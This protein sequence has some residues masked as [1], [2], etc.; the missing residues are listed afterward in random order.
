M[1]CTDPDRGWIE[2]FYELGIT[3]G[4]SATP[5]DFCAE[6][7]ATRAQMAVFLATAMVL[8]GTVPA[9][10]TVP[11]VGSYNCTTGGTSLFADVSPTD[12]TCQFIHYI[13]AN[14]V[15]AGCSVSPRNYCPSATTPHWQM[16]VFVSQAWNGFQ[17][18]PPG[19][20]YTFR[21]PA[22]TLL[23]EYQDSK[24]SKDYVYL[25]TRL[26]GTNQSTGG[27]QFHATDHLGSTR[28]TTNAAGAV[29]ESR[30]YWPWGEEVSPPGPG[31]LA[32][33]GMELDLEASRP[34][35]YDHA[36]N[37]ETGNGRFLSPDMLGGKIG[38]PQSWNRYTYARNNPLRYV[39][40]NGKQSAEAAT[41][42]RLLTLLPTL[43]V[44]SPPPLVAV[45]A[46]AVLGGFGVGRAIGE[47][48]AHS[49]S[50]IPVQ[51]V[52]DFLNL[53][54][55]GG[56]LGKE[57]TREHV[58]QVAGQLEADG[59]KVVGGGGVT[60]EEYIP[61]ADGGRKGSAYPD[62]T[63]VGPNGEVVR[64][65]TVDTRADGVTPTTREQNNAEKIQKLR[66]E[67]DLRLIPKPD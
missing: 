26:V 22:G 11:G 55:S 5:T 48:F 28:L 57:S 27:W 44:A 50:L 9:S 35:Y 65:N 45:G 41:A 18:V 17:Y 12:G 2:K 6:S 53:D 24:V 4:C 33:A 67:D 23:T 30:K 56:R 39:D 13:F 54:R 34:R 60:K 61:P 43:G 47:Y 16:E 51:T 37:L 66:P 20:T 40:P 14:N 19:A 59:Y 32:F 64:V 15:T 10:G 38:D 3:A 29:I 63:A 8:P 1:P 62:I 7:T 36:R 49:P 58:G 52:P 46:V 21:G 25:G 31:R 42:G